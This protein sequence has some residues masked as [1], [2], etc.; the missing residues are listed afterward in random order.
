MFKIADGR[1]H[2]YQ[3]DLDRQITVDD[4]SIVEVHF[5]NRTDDCSL[6]VAVVDGVANVPNVIL[7]NSFDVRVFG[8]DGKATLHEKT[9]KVKPR[10]KP[11]DYFYTEIEIRNYDALQK[12][13]E[14]SVKDMQKQVSDS[15]T[16]LQEYVA[17]SVEG[18][19]TYVTDSTDSLHEYVTTNVESMQTYVEETVQTAIESI[20]SDVVSINGKSG[21]VTLTASD[22]NALP[23]DTHIPSIEGLATKEYVDEAVASSTAGL[24]EE[25]VQQMIDNSLNAIGNAEDGEY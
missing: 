8:Y 24:S 15:T 9:F 7:H 18:M 3:W 13:V 19:Q 5:C 14:D 23:A 21:I 1:E 11:S 17:T 6:V 12:Y 22:V 2:F 20:D 10:T 25:E 4:A 16:S